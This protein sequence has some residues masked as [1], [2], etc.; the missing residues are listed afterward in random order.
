M[1]NF[2]AE[3][4]P[5]MSALNSMSQQ[6][7]RDLSDLLRFFGEDPSSTRVEDF[8]GVVSSFAIALQVSAFIRARVV[9]LIACLLQ[10]AEDEIRDAERLASKGVKANKVGILL[11]TKH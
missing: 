8:F 10:K 1:Q 3:S 6:L 7:D 4:E 5:A 9:S 11:H 2:V